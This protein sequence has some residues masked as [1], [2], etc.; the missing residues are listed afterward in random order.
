MDSSDEPI[1]PNTALEANARVLYL[2]LSV[3]EKASEDNQ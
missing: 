2:V 1:E 3:V